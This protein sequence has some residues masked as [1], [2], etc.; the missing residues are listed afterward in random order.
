MGKPNAA[1]LGKIFSSKQSGDPICA[2]VY[3]R[4]CTASAVVS[5]KIKE[6]GGC[7]SHLV[8]V[9]VKLIFCGG[10]FSPEIQK[11]NAVHDLL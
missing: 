4:S 10:L 11:G 8:G 1:E 3:L 5:Y 2:S 7:F 6:G 9:L